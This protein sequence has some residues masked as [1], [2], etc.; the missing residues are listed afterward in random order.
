[1]PILKD[2]LLVSPFHGK[3]KVVWFPS[4]IVIL[5]VSSTT[6]ISGSTPSRTV[7]RCDISVGKGR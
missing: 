4:S 5:K 1:M 3:S 7:P 2:F 6:G